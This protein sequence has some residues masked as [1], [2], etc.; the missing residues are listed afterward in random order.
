MVLILFVLMLL[1]LSQSELGVAV[2][3][4]RKVFGAFFLSAVAVLLIV[5][6][7]T[8]WWAGAPNVGDNFGSIEEVG[9]VLYTRYLLPFEI[10]SILLLVAMI[11]A[12]VL[13]RGKQK[14]KS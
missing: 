3:N 11:G 14:T 5:R 12:I 1:N 9:K 4:R 8:R 6:L 7:S 10:T 13:T 2:L